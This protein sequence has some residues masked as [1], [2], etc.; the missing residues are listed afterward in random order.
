MMMVRSCCGVS[1][2]SAAVA[3]LK[4]VCIQ[5]SADVWPLLLLCAICAGLGVRWQ[6]ASC[7]AL[8]HVLLKAHGTASIAA[9]DNS[10]SSQERERAL[11]ARSLHAWCL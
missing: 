5:A 7:E 11:A 8:V 3:G 1:L 2:G 4:D 9:S 10:E 6:L